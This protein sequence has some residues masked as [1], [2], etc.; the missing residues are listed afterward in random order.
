MVTRGWAEKEGRGTERCWS[1][2]IKLHLGRINFGIHHSWVTIANNNVAY[3][4][5]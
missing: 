3:I 2:G 1:M 5:R 4:S